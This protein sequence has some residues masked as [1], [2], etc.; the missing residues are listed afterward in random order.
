MSK[1][2]LNR[3]K[4]KASR[5]F[6]SAYLGRWNFDWLL[7]AEAAWEEYDGIATANECPNCP[8][9]P[10]IRVDERGHQYRI[11]FHDIFVQV[12][13]RT[14]IDAAKGGFT[15]DITEWQ[16]AVKDAGYIVDR[17]KEREARKVGR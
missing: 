11:S 8:Q 16:R 6:S 1:S 10:R 12:T 14:F 4:A 15:G 5:D 9:F 2:D 7:L 17:R 3:L 13:H